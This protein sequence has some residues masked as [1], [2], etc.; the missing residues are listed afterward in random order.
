VHGRNN[1]V[2]FR[3]GSI[4]K[5]REQATFTRNDQPTI[6]DDV[7]LTLP[8]FLKFDRQPHSIVN[9]RSETRCIF[10]RGAQVSQYTIRMPML[11]SITAVS[12]V[13]RRITWHTHTGLA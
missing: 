9:Q 10:S 2:A 3:P 5:F 1:V 13:A 6:H 4:Q 12:E 8:T 7:E 11:K